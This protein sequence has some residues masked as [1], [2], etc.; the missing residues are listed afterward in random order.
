MWC[1]HVTCY[2]SLCYFKKKENER[3]SF[4]FGN[5]KIIRYLCLKITYTPFTQ[6]LN[7]MKE[8]KNWLEDFIT[9]TAK[10]IENMK[11]VVPDH[12]NIKRFEGEVS[13][14]KKTVDKIEELTKK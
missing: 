11:T 10:K 13:M 4:L 2:N 1:Y 3:Y 7:K 6:N 9:H 14:A 5:V 12:R 8:L